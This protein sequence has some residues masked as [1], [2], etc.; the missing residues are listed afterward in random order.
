MN[1]Y[2]VYQM[3]LAIKMHF[4]YDGYDYVK[5]HGKVR[6]SRDAF[7]KRKDKYFFEK[8]KR[9]YPEPEKMKMFLI[10][11]LIDNDE[12]WI[13]KFFEEECRAKYFRLRGRLD[14]LEYMLEE[15]L[16]VIFE[17]IGGMQFSSI[18]KVKDGQHPILL[19]LYL[20]QRIKLETLIIFNMILKCFEQWDSKISDTIIYPQI[21]RKCLKYSVFLDIL[22]DNKNKFTSIILKRAKAHNNGEKD[23]D[24]SI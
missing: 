5:Y 12:K 23:Y 22:V 8:L 20:E 9:K 11:N 7:E 17:A 15:D 24:F 6:T 21:K 2:D 10:A 13:G 1:S 3:Y 18:F 4:H 16:K 14:C 19:T